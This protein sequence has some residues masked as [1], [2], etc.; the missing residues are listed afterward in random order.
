MSS[1]VGLCGECKLG[2]FGDG[3]LKNGMKLKRVF[4]NVKSGMIGSIFVRLILGSS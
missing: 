3:V 1:F 2:R 4:E